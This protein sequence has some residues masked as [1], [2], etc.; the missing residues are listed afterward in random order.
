LAA[1]LGA[2]SLTLIVV[3]LPLFFLARAL[4]PARGTG[5]PLIHTG[6]V[7]AV[8][9]SVGVGVIAGIA[10]GAWYRRGA[11]LRPLDEE[12]DWRG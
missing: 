10:V 2:A 8:P 1:A 11:A 4:E 12:G 5:R 3:C 7:V 6:I 9:V